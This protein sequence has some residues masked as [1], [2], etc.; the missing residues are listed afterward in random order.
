MELEKEFRENLEEFDTNIYARTSVNNMPKITALVTHS[1]EE[2]KEID[3]IFE[4]AL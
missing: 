4:A 3:R 1:E 2:Q